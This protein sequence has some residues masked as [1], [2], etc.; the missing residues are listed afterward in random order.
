[1]KMHIFFRNTHLST[2]HREWTTGRHP[3]SFPSCSFLIF[4]DVFVLWINVEIQ[5]KKS[6]KSQSQTCPFILIRPKAF[7]T[8]DCLTFWEMCQSKLRMFYIYMYTC[9]AFS[10]S[11]DCT[12]A[13]HICF[14][15]P[16]Q[17]EKWELS[18]VYSRPLSSWVIHKKMWQSFFQLCPQLSNQITKTIQSTSA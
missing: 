10:K 18:N 9:F 12:L 3:A 1:M 7:V 5:V 17:S 2:I 11:K 4:A 13:S 16:I 6:I 15:N 8:S 14:V